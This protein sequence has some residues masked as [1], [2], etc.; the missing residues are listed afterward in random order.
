MPQLVPRGKWVFG[1]VVVGTEREMPIPDE[2]WREYRFEVGQE[3]I[4][5]AGSRRSGG[6]AVSSP[7]LM[8][9]LSAQ[10][11]GYSL[12]VLGQS[13]FLVRGMVTIPA[14]VDVHPGD[15]L[16]AVRG[17]GRGLSFLTQGPI[18]E[19]APKHPELGVFHF[20]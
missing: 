9:G 11:G 18:Y 13:R 20:S 8:A 3:A 7:V 1:W 14:V 16:L 15:R 4:F 12:R 19:E 10:M 5:I 17:S 6:F 2:A